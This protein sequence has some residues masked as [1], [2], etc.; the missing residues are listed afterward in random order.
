[1]NWDTIVKEF[2][3]LWVVID[4]IGSIPVFI[5]ITTGLQASMQRKIA[6]KAASIAAAI[7]LFFLVLGQLLLEQLSISLDAFQIAG[8]IVLF[9]FALT[10][11]FGDSKPDEEKKQIQGNIG[12]L[13]V[14]PLAIPSLASP[15]AM[16]SVVMLTDNHRFSLQE[17]IVTALVMLSVI[18]ITLILFLMA[19]PIQRVIGNAGASVVSRVMGLILASVAVNNILIG[20]TAY[21]QLG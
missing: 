6:I 1:M 17:Q 15:G 12:H 19:G 14:F 21:F 18:F 7:L 16:L 4:P 20:I 10:M 2:I 9:L 3:S 5:A 8:G 13:A 11:I